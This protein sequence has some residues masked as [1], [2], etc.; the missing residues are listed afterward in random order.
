MLAN[1]A[2]PEEI[3]KSSVDAMYI[4]IA[5]KFGSSKQN[6]QNKWN[7]LM[8]EIRIKLKQG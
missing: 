1:G 3:T 6:A 7:T 2:I 8:K 5:E 4:G